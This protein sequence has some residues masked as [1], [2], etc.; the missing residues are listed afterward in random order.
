MLIGIDGCKMGWCAAVLEEGQI[1]IQCF[2]AF[3]EIFLAYPQA[4]MV[5]V[6]M[7][8]G[9]GSAQV[10][11]TI[12]ASLR[13][14]LKPHRHHSV[15]TPPVREA[16]YQDNYEKAKEANRSITGKAI[17]I[18]A[19]NIA[20]KIREVDQ[21]LQQNP[22]RESMIYE[23]HPELIF[24]HLNGRRHLT[25]KKSAPGQAGVNERLTVLKKY[26]PE[27]QKVFSLAKNQYPRNQVKQDDIADALGV[28]VAAAKASTNT[29]SLLEQI[30]ALDE[31]G[32][33]IRLAYFDPTR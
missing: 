2:A 21:F 7:P 25:Y 17:S 13:Q 12:D 30:P 4:E 19:W 5:W 24:Y 20:P 28:L 23:A 3:A 15:F 29:I 11:R 10:E 1:S 9:L 31:K 8:I 27:I 6:D 18:Q 14:V 26:F 16:L 22:D 33:S 32:I